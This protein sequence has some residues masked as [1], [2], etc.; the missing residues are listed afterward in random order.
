MFIASSVSFGMPFTVFIDLFHQLLHLLSFINSV[1][2][3]PKLLKPMF[4]YCIPLP[5][6]IFAPEVHF[7]FCMD[8]APAQPF[9][10]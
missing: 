5:K 1:L 8:E 3:N 6:K 9:A 7:N 10:C 4:S 2:K